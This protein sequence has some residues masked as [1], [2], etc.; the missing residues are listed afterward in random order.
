MYDNINFY[1]DIGLT[2]SNNLLEDILTNG[3]DIV[4]EKLGETGNGIP[5]A[6]ISIEG[7]DGQRLNFRVNPYGISL[8]GKNSSICK[9]FLGNS[10]ETL[11]LAQ[12]GEAVEEISNR[13]SIDI[14]PARVSRIDVATNFVM[15]HSPRTYHSCFAHLSRYMR[16]EI[17][18]NLYFKTNR[19]VLNFY[20]K[21]KE[22]RDKKFPIPENFKEVE[23]ILRYE[24][25]FK[26]DVSKVF[27]RVI[28]VKDLC[29][30]GFFD[31]IC[32]KWQQYYWNIT[33]QNPIVFNYETS[34]MSTKEFVN[35]FM[36]Q[37][38]ETTGGIEFAYQV[39]EDSK[40]AGALTNAKASYLRKR[41]NTAYDETSTF[42]NYDYVEEINS[43]MREYKP[44]YY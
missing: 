17:G 19:I 13:L 24:I 40:K 3:D 28:T 37:G 7:K 36:V 27:H 32:Q 39:I 30:K 22:Y 15:E 43:K 1:L 21:K 25:R 34:T 12:F 8:N 5:F 31:E 9:Y 11:T 2:E 18:G 42:V 6:Y 4:L 41:I 44:S 10:F 33:K 23:N 38:I 14:S 26:K 29:S 20:D 35:Y 16:G